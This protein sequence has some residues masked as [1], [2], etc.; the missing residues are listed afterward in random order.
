MLRFFKN[1]KIPFIEWRHYAYVLSLLL[2]LPGI[3][4]LIIKG[5][6]RYGIDFTGGT[7]VQLRFE[8]EVPLDKLRERLVDVELGSFEL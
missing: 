1:P 6:P 2:L 3:A 8:R 4:S 7:L 5:G